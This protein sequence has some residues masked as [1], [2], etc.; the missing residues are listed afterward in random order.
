MSQIFPY[1]KKLY[2]KISNENNSFQLYTFIIHIQNIYTDTFKITP[3][4]LQ[5]LARVYR[6]TGN[7][8]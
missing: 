6:D 7:L 2:H 4:T 8:F 3:L 5:N 1:P